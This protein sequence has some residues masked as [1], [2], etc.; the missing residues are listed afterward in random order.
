MATGTVEV[1]NGPTATQL[2]T[3]GD[4][5]CS[6]TNGSSTDTIFLGDTNA[7]RPT[8]PSDVIPLGPGAAISVDGKS[9]LFAVPGGSS[10][11]AA[12]ILKG[13]VAT[14]GEIS[15]NGD[16]IINGQSGPLDINGVGGFVLPGQ[17]A[18]IDNNPGAVNAGPGATFKVAG[19]LDVSTYGSVILSTNSPANSSVAAGA[20]ICALW[21]LVWTDAAGNVI[22]TDSVSVIMSAGFSIQMP[23]K[24]SNVT[25][26]LVNVGSVGTITYTNPRTIS[27]WGDYRTV[28]KPEVI[29]SGNSGLSTITG[30]ILQPMGP[31]AQ[32]ITSWIASFQNSSAV[33]NTQYLMPLPLWYGSVSGWY[34]QTGQPL[35]HDPTI[36]DLTYATQNSINPGTAYTQGI[37]QNLPNSVQAAPVPIQ[38]NSPPTQLAILFETGAAVGSTFFYLTGN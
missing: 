16:V 38:Y 11:I 34:Q 22:A 8:D 12:Y 20:A 35:A 19:P 32:T 36:V 37:I 21:Q 18:L 5:P 25:L 10:Q 9:N 26:N 33:A 29:T 23:I 28:Q 2:V 3:A 30:W 15:V 7:I 6:I 1:S 13:G 14:A 31:P 4:G 27:L 17:L 24:G